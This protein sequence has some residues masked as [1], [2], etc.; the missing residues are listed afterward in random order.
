MRKLVWCGAAFAVGAA[1]AVYMAANYAANH[2]DSYLAR[3]AAGAAYVGTRANPFVLAS[4]L[5]PTAGA[6]GNS[7]VGGMVAGAAGC[8]H[9]QLEKCE[10]PKPVPAAEP[11]NPEAAEAAEPV[12]PICPEVPEE[13]E[14][15]DGREDPFLAG[16][17]APPV[18]P[19]APAETEEP[20]P[21]PPPEGEMTEGIEI[22]AMPIE[23]PS[24]GAELIPAPTA[25]QEAY[26][27]IAAP[28]ADMADAEE[29][30]AEESA[31]EGPAPANCTE[32]G[33]EGCCSWLHHVMKFFG[34]LPENPAP[35]APA[36]DDS[37]PE[38]EGQSS[39]PPQSPHHGCPYMNMGCPYMG[40]PY[41]YSRCAPAP[42]EQ[43]KKLHKKKVKVVPRNT[44]FEI[45]AL[46]K[47]LFAAGLCSAPAGEGVICPVKKPVSEL[48][49]KKPVSRYIEETPR[50]TG[51]DTM[52]FRP[53]DDPR[54]PPGTHPF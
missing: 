35:T 21:V 5:V 38:G 11:D 46:W 26:E 6:Q 42:T 8:M 27:P 1:A 31:D 33:D 14:C 18:M 53:T 20:M 16:L 13:P 12:E 34:L 50:Q 32:E 51:I 30:D 36:S 54:D 9:G 28:A 43:P 24:E 48:P 47:K 39:P 52:E 22:F 4:G 29:S 40:C 2:P 45:E 41:P 7:V 17:L 3:C 44:S 23:A 49:R 37:S 10:A 19:E 15:G 25:T